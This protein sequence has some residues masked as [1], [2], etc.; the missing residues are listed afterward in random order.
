MPEYIRQYTWPE[1]CREWLLRASDRGVLPVTVDDAGAEWRR[2]FTLDVA[3]INQ[4]ERQLVLGTCHW[5]EGPAGL[6]LIEELAERSRSVV[7]KDEDDWTIYYLGFARDG[8]AE[9]AQER[10]ADMLDAARPGSRA[11]NRWRV[12]GVRL[13]SLEDVDEDLAQWT[14]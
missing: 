8:W 11:S 3:G 7:P 10:A 2:N 6:E 9:D 12:A 1:L 13:L 14:R 5:D 4:S